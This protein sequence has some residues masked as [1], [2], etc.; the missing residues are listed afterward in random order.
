MKTYHKICRACGEAY[1]TPKYRQIFCSL[2]CFGSSLSKKTRIC[3][4][5][6]KRKRNRYF[7]GDSWLCNPCHAAYKRKWRRTRHARGAPFS[8]FVGERLAN[9]R[10]HAKVVG[11][12]FKIDSE[13]LITLWNKQS[14]KCF[15]T[16]KKMTYFQTNG[17][18]K[19]MIYPTQASLDRLNPEDGY[20]RGNLA[21]ICWHVN[22][23]KRRSTHHEFIQI[24]RTIGARRYRLPKV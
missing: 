6:R 19:G 11:V 1:K 3:T 10:Y 15:Y 22:H 24:C 9:Y 4:H 5:C 20:T 7:A 23:M 16:G 14:G 21:W 13:Y 18:K 2:K 12:D 17:K 8:S